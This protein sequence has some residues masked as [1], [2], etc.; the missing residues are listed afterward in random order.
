MGNLIYFNLSSISTDT[1]AHSLVTC[2]Q[3]T[4]SHKSLSEAFVN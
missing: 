4:T 3:A 1:V 2:Q